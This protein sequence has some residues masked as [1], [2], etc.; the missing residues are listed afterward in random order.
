MNIDRIKEITAELNKTT[1]DDIV[2]VGYGYKETEGKTTNEKCIIFTVIRKKPLSEIPENERIPSQIDIDGEI[3]NTDVIQGVYRL[4]SY[5]DCSTSDPNFY[6]WQTTAP[7][8]RNKIRPIQGGLSL[9]NYDSLVFSTGTLGFI[10]VDNETNSLVGVSNNHVLIRDAFL[11]STREN[12]PQYPIL[13]FNVDGDITTQPNELGNKS[14]ANRIGVV[15]KYQPIVPSNVGTNFVDVACLAIEQLDGDGNAVLSESDSWKQYGISGMTSTPRFATT[16]EIDTVLGESNRVFYT[17][18]RTTG[19]KGEGLTK[20]YCTTEVQSIAIYYSR[21]AQDVLCIM[22]E[23]F[24]LQAKGPDTPEG[25][26]C[27]YPSHFGDSGSA[28]LT[29]IEGEYVIVGLL[30]AGRVDIVNGEP[31]DDTATT[32]CCRIDRIVEAM[33][34]SAWNGSLSGVSFSDTNNVETIIVSGMSDQKIITVNGKQYW[35]VGITQESP[36]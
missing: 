6:S 31:T 9:T 24:E 36:T 35:Q 13:V 20:L 26:W 2:S 29:V 12:L 21:Q 19:A 8:N 10:A 32:V 27:L 4:R 18:G 5:I 23:S 34:I 16:A 33:N 30:Y 17:S 3:Y 28:I 25:D 14:A 7:D 15:K 11:A 22:N 1:S